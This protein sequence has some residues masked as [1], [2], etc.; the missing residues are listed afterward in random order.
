[1]HD[2]LSGLVIA[3]G[4]LSE[5]VVRE[6]TSALLQFC[7]EKNALIY[8][9]IESQTQQEAASYMQYVCNSLL[10][11]FSNNM[12]QDRVILP[13]LK[14]VEL[15]LRHDI[16]QRI[17]PHQSL[18]P[19]SL[20]E[21]VN[22]ESNATNNVIKI[23]LCIDILL[24]MLRWE[25]PVRGRAL[26]LLVVLLGH[27]YPRIRKHAADALYVQFL[28]DRWAVGASIEDINSQLE[29]RSATNSAGS[30]EQS[31]LYCGFAR[32]SDSL[33]QAQDILVSTNWET[34]TIELARNKRL[35]ICNLLELKMTQRVVDST[36]TKKALEV[37][38]DELDSY[39]SLVREVGY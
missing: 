27:K 3:I 5:T 23:K 8:D 18:F 14:T 15:L 19:N 4:G 39:E 30:T 33:Q 32:N 12:N 16:L 35:Q 25:E 26:K 29:Q 10:Q 24:H 11:L 17:R 2:L 1:M 21:S 31:A 7:K 20:L 13:L 22:K 9:V 28:S 34:C 6:S 36:K 37:K 38:A